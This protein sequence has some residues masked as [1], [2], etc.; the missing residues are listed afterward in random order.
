MLSVVK[1]KSSFIKNHEI[2]G[3]LS[4]LGIRTSLSNIPLTG[5]IFFKVKKSFVVI[6]FVMISLK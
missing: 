5:D 4:E 3:L 2:S 1:K 6:K